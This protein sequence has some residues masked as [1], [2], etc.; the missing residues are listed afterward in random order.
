V[1]SCSAL[2]DCQLHFWAAET[3]SGTRNRLDIP[4][5]RSKLSSQTASMP[6]NGPRTDFEIR[7]PN[8]IYSLSLSPLMVSVVIVT[9]K[10]L[11]K[12]AG[13]VANCPCVMPRRQEHDIVFGEIFGR[14]IIHHDSKRSREDQSDMR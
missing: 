12:N 9:T 11:D 13:F 14:T 2:I 1:N 5:Q 3:I 10:E 4:A 8:L 6:I 7:L